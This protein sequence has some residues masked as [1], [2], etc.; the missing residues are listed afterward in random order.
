MYLLPVI[1]VLQRNEFD[2]KVWPARSFNSLQA[3]LNLAG[4]QQ[5]LR[6]SDAFRLVEHLNEISWPI[7]QRDTPHD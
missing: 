5:P 6:K 3:A 1:L 7:S 2:G 4:R